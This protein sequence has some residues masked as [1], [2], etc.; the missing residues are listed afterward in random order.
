MK[1]N[2]STFDQNVKNTLFALLSFDHVQQSQPLPF[3]VADPIQQ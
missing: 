2:P 3:H 1:N